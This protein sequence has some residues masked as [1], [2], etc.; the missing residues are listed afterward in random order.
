MGRLLLPR[1]LRYVGQQPRLVLNPFEPAIDVHYRVIPGRHHLVVLGLGGIPARPDVSLGALK[2]HQRVGIRPERF[3]LQIGARQVAFD[4]PEGT[5]PLAGLQDCGQVRGSEPVGALRHQGGERART[6][7]SMRLAHI[8]DLELRR[9]VH[10][11][12]PCLLSARPRWDCERDNTSKRYSLPAARSAAIALATSS[13]TTVSIRL[14]RLRCSHWR[15]TGSSRSASVCSSAPACWLSAA[16]GAAFDVASSADRL[17]DAPLALAAADCGGDSGSVGGAEAGSGSMER[18]ASVGMG[19][20][21]CGS[22]VAP[23]M[24]APGAAALVALSFTAPAIPSAGRRTRGS[25]RAVLLTRSTGLAMLAAAW[26]FDSGVSKSGGREARSVSG[27]ESL[28]SS[29]RAASAF[30]ASRARAA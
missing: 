21:G 1:Q 24:A 26:S 2:D 8:L 30:A 7:Q 20:G 10:G 13:R 28:M 15:I 29:A 19:L 16:A 18:E 23:A 22:L 12:A 14:G 6:H 5:G 25:V 4:A 17:S 9:H 3:P 27:R 11:I